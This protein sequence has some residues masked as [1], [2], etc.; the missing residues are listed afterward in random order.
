M[1]EPKPLPACKNCD[2]ICESPYNSDGDCW[3]RMT[4]EERIAFAKLLTADSGETISEERI[5]G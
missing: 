1:A 5:S 3:N 2:H 4:R